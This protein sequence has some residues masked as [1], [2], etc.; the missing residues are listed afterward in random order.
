MTS[1]EN[2]R[3]NGDTGPRR[4]P[5]TAT[6]RTSVSSDNENNGKLQKL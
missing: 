1:N 3:H 2:K 6:N 4:P 5:T